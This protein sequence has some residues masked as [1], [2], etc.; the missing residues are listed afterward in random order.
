MC[1]TR[2]PP[3]PPSPYDNDHFKTEPKRSS[4]TN[5][6]LPP[7]QKM[8]VSWKLVNSNQ[9][10]VEAPTGCHCGL[11]P[12]HQPSPP[13]ASSPTPYSPYGLPHPLPTLCADRRI[14]TDG[15]V[16]SSASCSGVGFQCSTLPGHT[17]N[18]RSA[19]D[20]PRL[21]ARMQTVRSDR[22]SR[23]KVEKNPPAPQKKKKKK[24][25]LR[26]RLSASHTAIKPTRSVKISTNNQISQLAG[27]RTNFRAAIQTKHAT[28][29]NSTSSN[30]E[31]GSYLRERRGWLVQNPQ[32]E[33]PQQGIY[34]NGQ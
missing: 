16:F 14:N 22:L 31:K 24:T 4:R 1:S 8:L 15:W 30:W 20:S 7:V 12:K 28:D 2:P 25:G 10:E 23:K 3:T 17:S 18:I 34:C 21:L 29:Q 19:A 11:E 13:P 32:T 26:Q 5:E 27:K 33:S 6:T 9:R